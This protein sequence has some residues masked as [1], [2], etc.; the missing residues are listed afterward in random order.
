MAKRNWSLFIGSVSFG[1]VVGWLTRN[2][3]KLEEQIELIVA[4]VLVVIGIAGLIAKALSKK[5]S[6]ADENNPD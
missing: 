6:H 2:P 3:T 5:V 1:I 4:G